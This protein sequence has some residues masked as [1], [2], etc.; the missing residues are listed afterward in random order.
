MKAPEARSFGLV[1]RVEGSKEA[2]LQAAFS[3]ANTI[4]SM[5]PVAVAGFALVFYFAFLLAAYFV[6][7]F[8][9]PFQRTKHNL[10][11]SR[12]H[13]VAEGSSLTHS[14]THNRIIPL[15]HFTSIGRVAN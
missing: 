9:S 12:D 5:S 8:V 13:S 11:F 15:A 4:A 2:C 1:S 3:T 7:M 10:N 6:F 14:L